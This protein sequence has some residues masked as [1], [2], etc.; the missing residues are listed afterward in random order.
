MQE[1]PTVKVEVTSMR[2][3]PALAAQVALDAVEN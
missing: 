2:E 1:E 3:E